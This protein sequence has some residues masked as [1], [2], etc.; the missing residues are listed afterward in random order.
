MDQ[1][2]GIAAGA[3]GVVGLYFLY[4]AA[5]KGLPAAVAWFKTWWNKGKAELDAL[6]ADVATAQ[7]AAAALEAKLQPMIDAVKNDVVA[8]KAKVGI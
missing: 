6:K 8:L 4:L 5:T 3:A 7:T 2:F 1:F